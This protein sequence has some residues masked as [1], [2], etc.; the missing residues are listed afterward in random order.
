M[1][2]RCVFFSFCLALVIFVGLGSNAAGQAPM[3]CTTQAF[4]DLGLTDIDG[5]AVTINNA[6]IVAAAAPLPEHCFVRGVIAPEHYF[7]VRLPTTT[8]NG[9]FYQVGGGG[10]DG[11]VNTQWQLGARNELCHRAGSGGHLSHHNVHMLPGFM[12]V[13]PLKE[14]YY[15]DFYDDLPADSPD[16]PNTFCRRDD[17]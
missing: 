16:P 8:W 13:F 2:H 12:V 1:R 10:W 3:D 4:E 6:E 11:S 17:C 5:R 7:E 9:K 15:T 14:P